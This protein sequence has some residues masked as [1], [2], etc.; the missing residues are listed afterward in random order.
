MYTQDRN[1][2]T[3]RCTTCRSRQHRFQYCPKNQCNAC[4][5]Y[6]HIMKDCSVKFCTNC[7]KKNGHVFINCPNLQCT[8][9]DQVGHSKYRCPNPRRIVNEAKEQPENLLVDNNGDVL[10]AWRDKNGIVHDT[11]EPNWEANWPPCVS[12]Q[13]PAFISTNATKAKCLYYYEVEP[14][15]N[16]NICGICLGRYTKQDEFNGHEDIFICKD[17]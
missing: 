2:N 15:P 17:H 8:N 7:K 10:Y 5:N 13:K 6:G 16:A 11:K 14:G 3:Y 9:C 1:V 4:G 12:C